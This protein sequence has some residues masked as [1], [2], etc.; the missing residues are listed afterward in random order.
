MARAQARYEPIRAEMQR[1]WHIMI[2]IDAWL[3]GFD[4]V[5]GAEHRD[6]ARAAM[7]SPPKWLARHKA[8][9]LEDA[10]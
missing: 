3:S 5:W 4:P 9:E 7:A 6:E 1:R 10:A 8:P 2:L